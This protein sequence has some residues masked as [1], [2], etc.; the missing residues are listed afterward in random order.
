MKRLL[1]ARTGAL[2]T[3]L[4][5]LAPALARAQDRVVVLAEPGT[6]V[7]AIQVLVATGPADEP[8]GKAGLAYLAAR[9]VTAPLRATL[10]S[11]GAHLAVDA[12]KDALSFT[13]TAAP[14]AWKDASRSLLVA[15]FRDPPE[16]DV[17]ERERAAIRQELL[18]R[19][20]NPADAVTQAMDAAFYG[21][22]HPWG[23]P[24]VGN[25]ESVAALSP[26]DVESFLR[27]Y[28]TADRTV[29]AVVG[30]VEDR[31]VRTHLS[32]FMEL[33]GPL[34]FTP[35]PPH[36]AE[37]PVSEDYNSVTTWTVVSY[38][39]PADADLEALRFIAQLAADELSFSPSRQGIYNSRGEVISRMGGGEVRLEVVTAPEEAHDWA[40]RMVSLVDQVAGG[41][42]MEEIFRTR[43]RRY[44]GE[45]LRSLAA[46]EDRAR[47]LARRLLVTGKGG[48]LVPDLDELTRERLRNAVRSLTPPTTVF[49]GPKR[50]EAG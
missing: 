11:L 22:D 29:V 38:G 43:L 34:R 48:T 41:S 18:A 33:R 16:A 6:P 30:P 32:D 20:S 36:P 8:E 37:E 7:V 2:L 35:L 19:Q 3:F 42:T 46:P 21:P 24:T 10:D 12:Q 31:E 1:H 50:N 17:V 9:S 23:R 4:L 49:L 5:L 40:E 15:L 14:D 44:R 13:L 26:G 25:P 47:E 27:A 28:F 45:R 39:F